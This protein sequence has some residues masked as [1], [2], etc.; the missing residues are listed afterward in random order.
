MRENEGFRKW[1]TKRNKKAAYQRLPVAAQ[2]FKLLYI[3]LGIGALQGAHNP[4]FSIAD[5]TV[6]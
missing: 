5:R 2:R 3:G 4:K 1:G 6:L